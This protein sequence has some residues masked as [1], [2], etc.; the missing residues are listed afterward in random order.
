MR[1]SCSLGMAAAAKHRIARGDAR[2]VVHLSPSPSW[3][4]LV[5]HHMFEEI[6]LIRLRGTA[7]ICCLMF[8]ERSERHSEAW[9]RR[10][11]GSSRNLRRLHHMGFFH[12]NDGRTDGLTDTDRQADADRLP[13]DD[14]VT[15][16]RSA[17][18][19]LPL[20]THPSSSRSS[21]DNR[22]DL[23]HIQIFPL[24]SRFFPSAA[25]ARHLCSRRRH[26]AGITASFVSINT[27]ARVM[28]TAAAAA[29]IVVAVAITCNF[30]RRTKRDVVVWYHAIEGESVALIRSFLP[31]FRWSCFSLVADR[32]IELSLIR[33]W[34]SFSARRQ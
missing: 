10:T 33:C 11:E 4:G 15:E 3:F 9:R 19:C 8:E 6:S 21:L 25:F 22:P 17:N 23:S 5:C 34:M 2:L 31:P 27:H 28:M 24:H 1:D 29:M 18:C 7:P 30:G 13:H 12:L 14:H 20:R 16:G 26:R 32:W